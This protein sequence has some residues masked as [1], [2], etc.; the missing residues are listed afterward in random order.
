MLV[1]NETLSIENILRMLNVESNNDKKTDNTSNV[2]YICIKKEFFDA[3]MIYLNYTNLKKRNYIEIIYKSPSIFLDGLFFKT[4]TINISNITVVTRERFYQANKD[5]NR[6]S[7][8]T[9]INIR[10]NKEHQIF[11]NMLKSI[12]QYINN[13]ISRCAK[14][15]HK[16]LQNI[17][18]GEYHYLRCENIISYKNNNEYELSFKSYLDNKS[19][20]ELKN[21]K[22]TNKKY[23]LTFNIS[24][25]YYGKNTLI[26]LIKCNKCTEII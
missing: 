16:E 21:N 12:D 15:I 6:P 22:N 14:E 3:N 7:F 2:Q 25:I 24:N 13:Y 1:S 18:N 10:L 26:P 20:N 8:I 23:E 9:H 11:I 4:P 17:E 19:I 5:F